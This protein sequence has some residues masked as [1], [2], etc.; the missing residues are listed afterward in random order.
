MITPLA[1]LAAYRAD[2][3]EA[4]EALSQLLIGGAAVGEIV[5]SVGF[6]LDED[7][8]GAIER[9]AGLVL[10]CRVGVFPSPQSRSTRRELA[11]LMVGV[12]PARTGPDTRR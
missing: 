7:P 12:E 10:M 11:D 1:S 6:G 8:I 5:T 4:P 3:F 9:M 2:G